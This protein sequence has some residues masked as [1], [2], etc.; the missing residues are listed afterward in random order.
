VNVA[1]QFAPAPSWRLCPR[2]FVSC[3]RVF[4]VGGAILTR[5]P[6]VRLML[7]L[8]GCNVLELAPWR[9]G[10]HA[11]RL[12]A[13]LG[14]DVVKVE[15]PGG[16]PMRAYPHLFRELAAGKRSRVLDLKVPGDLAACLELAA[17]AHVVLD[18]FR[19]GVA[20][21]LGVGYDAVRA[22]QP[23]VVYVAVS[24]F[25]A[26]G[27]L[28][29][30]PGHDV[31]Y[32]A[33][34]GA[35]W[36]RGAGGPVEP[37]F[38]AADLAAGTAAALAA[39]AGWVG[40][41][42]TGEGGFVDLAMTDVLTTW[43]GL[44]GVNASTASVGADASDEGSGLCS[45]GVFAVADGWVALGITTEDKFWASLCRDVGLD[46]LAGVG[47]AD[48]QARTAELRPVLAAA[49]APHER[50]RLVATLLAADVPVAPV[51][52][53]EEAA[54]LPHL[55]ERGTI[56]EDGDGLALGSVLRLPGVRPGPP[57]PAP[58]LDEH[59]G[60]GF[61]SPFPGDT[62]GLRPGPAPKNVRRGGSRRRP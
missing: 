39:V 3:S 18:G 58:V 2:G 41:L 23:A 12:L 48:R 49:L 25:G 37:A 35:L 57:L 33:W 26:D 47:F 44:P 22:V 27:P 32:L 29:Q 51:L 52:S 30:A 59:R 61:T 38:P 31:N 34:S 56:V 1:C 15:P 43:A 55:R 10:P 11:G 21:R 53:H 13:D 4:G 62:P 28:A 16:D 20:D 8:D 45:Y 36:R 17:G 46:D 7:P 54:V 42:R 50:D 24:G 9:P 14:A 19:P 40:W 6:R 60:E 5:P